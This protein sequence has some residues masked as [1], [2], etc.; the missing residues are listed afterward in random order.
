MPQSIGV[1]LMDTFCMNLVSPRD[2]SLYKTMHT[3][4]MCES[5]TAIETYWA[6]ADITTGRADNT[7]ILPQYHGDWWS[8][9]DWMPFDWSWA[10]ALHVF[11]YQV[12][13]P[14]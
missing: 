12:R 2:H 11:G 3:V 6:T 5:R 13:S 8:N 1:V 14:C 10:E 4:V 7:R 9:V